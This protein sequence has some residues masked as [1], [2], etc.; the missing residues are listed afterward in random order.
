VYRRSNVRI[1]SSEGSELF[2]MIAKLR[3]DLRGGELGIIACRMT[4]TNNIT[5]KLVV[6]VCKL[7]LNSR[8]RSR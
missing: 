3:L 2:R 6:M 7:P 4:T 8:E 5:R 1:C